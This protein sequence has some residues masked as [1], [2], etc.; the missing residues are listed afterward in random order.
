MKY[1]NKFLGALCLTAFGFASC[2]DDYS[3]LDYEV[4]QMP[5]DLAAVE[6]LKEYDD[7]K[8]YVDREANPNFKLGAGVTVSSYNEGGIEY[9]MAAH[10]F[11]EVTAGNAMKHASV[12]A[13]DG[14]MEFGP[15]ESF[16]EKAQAAGQTIYGHTLAWHSQQNTKYLNNIIADIIDPNYVP[17]YVPVTKVENRTCIIVPAGEKVENPWDH[18]FFLT[19]PGASF[20]EG[21]TWSVKMNIRAD[22]NTSGIDTQTHTGP[23]GYIHW[24]GI[25]T[26]SFTTEWTEYSA[27]GSMTAEQVGGNTFAFNLNAFAE[28]N[29]YYFDD[30]SFMLNGEE[31]VVNGNCDDPEGT[32]NYV[33]VAYKQPQVPS[34]I[35]DSYE[36]TVMEEKK[37]I[38][39][40][41]RTCIMVE[42]Q[43]MVA[44]PW[45]SQFWLFFPDVEFGEGQTVT[46]SMEVR[47]EKDATS[48]TQTHSGPGGYKHYVGIG[49]VPF[50]TDWTEYTYTGKIEGAMVGSNAFAF[51]L[52]DFKEANK[53]Y[54]DNISLKL[55]GVELVSNGNL[56][57]DD[58]TNFIAKEY[59][60]SSADA[61]SYAR[62]IEGYSI[63]VPGG[64][65]PLTPEEKK[66][67]LMWAMDNW[68][69]GMMTATKGYVSTWDAINE[70]ISGVGGE[71]YDLWSADNG[72]AKNFYW[73][74][75]LGDEEYVRFVI[76]KAR[77]YYTGE[78]PLKLFVNDYNLESDWDQNKKLKSLIHWIEVWESDNTTKIDG[79]GTQM[80]ISYYENP[81]TLASKN[82]A[83]ENM[84]KL[85]AATGKLVKISELD[86]AY[87]G[88]DGKVIKSKDLTEEQIKTLSDYYKYIVETYM[89]LV[90]ANQQ[91]G[92]T[93]W[94]PIDSPASS[95]WRGGEAVGLW[96][97]NYNRRH[98]YAGF[99]DGLAGAE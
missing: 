27:S 78:E 99:A 12:V 21:D 50:T 23:G 68:I 14:S 45:D 89:E 40:V 30:I 85:M 76:A 48:G 74:D 7:V 60:A 13:N 70:P 31:L 35:V 42:T 19:F 80:H 11:D 15:V 77:E 10:N 47:A 16:V 57:G 63:E 98:T 58:M 93:L 38:Q 28:A 5:A 83:I 82:A 55:D 9:R 54:F 88:A 36:Y 51:N 26:I 94:C 90:P 39:N 20:A 24:A 52:N 84:F 34:T 49:T 46:V 25:G 86:L 81:E 69:K 92:I 95:S 1:T 44:N 17:E 56:D 67:T 8:T 87:V 18:Q 43:D 64:R 66:D 59:P 32:T 53:Y 62:K 73:Q 79:I 65:T 72:D 2:A 61:T 96:D 22:K 71:F 91:Y 6:Y 29:N 4:G 41:A 37:V 3:L 75:Y 97:G 33:S